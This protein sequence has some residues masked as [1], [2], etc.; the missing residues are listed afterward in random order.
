MSLSSIPRS[1]HLTSSRNRTIMPPWEITTTKEHTTDGG[2]VLLLFHCL[3]TSLLTP[4][5]AQNASFS[6]PGNGSDEL[7]DDSEIQKHAQNQ[8]L[9]LVDACFGGGLVVHGAENPLL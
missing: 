6:S 8:K 2:S 9:I 4:R 5:L 3:F 1:S 7:C